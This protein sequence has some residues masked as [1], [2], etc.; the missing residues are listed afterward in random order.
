[1]FTHRHRLSR[2]ILLAPLLSLAALSACT[3]VPQHAQT[4]ADALVMEQMNTA[5]QS[6][7]DSLALLVRLDRGTAGKT[8]AA[9]HVE[10]GSAY[11]G[12]TVATHATPSMAPAMPA[13]A[14][15][16]TPLAQAQARTAAQALINYN[17][18]ALATR[19]RLHWD[20]DTSALLENI[21][22][23]I[24]YTYADVGTGTVPDMHIST[25]N[26]SA[27]DA[28]RSAANLIEPSASIHVFLQSRMI[29]LVHA[30]HP[31]TCPL[32]TPAR[33]SAE[34]A[35]ASSPAVSRSNQAR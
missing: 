34:A 3:T 32:P 7:A 25:D 22:S 35:S 1:M 24:G 19:L 27:E 21:A 17:R 8:P 13:T 30:G 29:C 14:Q 18:Q 15:P 2:A 6:A 28:L 10:A 16:Q 23:Q 33:E 26:V 4:H 20:G 9:P 11:L 5:V 12:D 31:A